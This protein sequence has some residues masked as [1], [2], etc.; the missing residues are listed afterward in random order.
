MAQTYFEEIR[1]GFLDPGYVYFYLFIGFILVIVVGIIGMIFYKMRKRKTLDEY[2]DA[3]IKRFEEKCHEK[4]LSS[5]E[6][7]FLKSGFDSGKIKHPAEVFENKTKLLHFCDLIAKRYES[8]YARNSKEILQIH[9]MIKHILKQYDFEKTDKSAVLISS[10]DLRIGQRIV[11]FQRTFL[12]KKP[13]IGSIVYLDDFFLAGFF[14]EPVD[15]LQRIETET[16]ID[17]TFNRENDAQYFFTSRVLQVNLRESN[18]N[19]GYIV[20]LQHSNKLY[21]TQKRHFVRLEVSKPVIIY[22]N[23]NDKKFPEPELDTAL[24]GTIIDISEGGVCI[25]SSK[26][27]TP[28][29]S[30][31]LDFTL[32]VDYKGIESLVVACH[33]KRNYYQLHIKFLFLEQDLRDNIRKYILT[34]TSNSLF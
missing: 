34:R 12:S 30:I 6:I 4:N 27:L 5:K 24:S 11:I 23:L 17:V 26:P 18:G 28:D 16:K 33:K 10:K 20:V 14:L 25:E 1:R 15:E 7:N 29:M 3:E 13:V 32:V 22:P 19:Q 2:Y 21:R 9:E 8:K 31:K